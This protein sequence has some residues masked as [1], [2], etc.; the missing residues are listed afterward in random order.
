MSA[1]RTSIGVGRTARAPP[2][3][4]TICLGIAGSFVLNGAFYSL[5]YDLLND[6]AP[7]SAVATGPIVLLAR[8]TMPAK[9]LI[10]IR[11]VAK[12]VASEKSDSCISMV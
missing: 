1:E 7:I 10:E 4:Y 3:G 6:F 2:D 12:G 11:H 5:P 9:D 8:T